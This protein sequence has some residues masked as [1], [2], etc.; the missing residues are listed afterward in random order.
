[1][2]WWGGWLSLNCFKTNCPTTEKPAAG[3]EG[4]AS[5]WEIN[6]FNSKF[7]PGKML[8]TLVLGMSG[9]IAGLLNR[10]LRKV[11]T[12]DSVGKIPP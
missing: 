9:G 1:V 7:V 2:G 5:P 10:G 8:P 12:F 3:W 6:A 4:A 11:V